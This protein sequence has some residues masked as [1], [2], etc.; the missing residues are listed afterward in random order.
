MENYSKDKIVDILKLLNYMGFDKVDASLVKVSDF[1]DLEDEV[2]KCTKCGLY[3]NRTNT[4][5]GKGPIDADILIIGEAPGREEDI[6]GKPFVGAAG[7]KLDEMLSEAG[8]EVGKVFIT[9]VVKCRPPG[10]RNPE[11]YEIMKCNPYLIKQIEVIKPKIIVL[12]GNVALSLVSGE[13]SGITKTRGKKLIYMSY[14]AIPTFHPAYVV[15]NPSSE[16]TVVQDFKQVIRSI[17]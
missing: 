4:V 1:A 17:S 7:Q 15:R 8:I 16:K 11:P 6:E 9:N 12:L 10:N 13:I 14:P 5:F 3:K 2:R